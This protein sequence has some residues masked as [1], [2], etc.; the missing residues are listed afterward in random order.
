MKILMF[1]STALMKKVNKSFVKKKNC[2]FYKLVEKL[3]VNDPWLLSK[4]SSFYS[5]ADQLD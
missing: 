4:T 1:R 2:F 5:I 3:P